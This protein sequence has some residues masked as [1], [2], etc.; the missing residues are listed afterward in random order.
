MEKKKNRDI[1]EHQLTEASPQVRLMFHYTIEILKIV[2]LSNNIEIYENINK[3][4]ERPGIHKD[5][6]ITICQL[7]LVAT[8]KPL[9]AQ[10]RHMNVILQR[11]SEG[12]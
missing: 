1:L 9:A 8:R 4:A 3:D 12:S 7:S 2:A 6:F 10:L 5:M 11:V